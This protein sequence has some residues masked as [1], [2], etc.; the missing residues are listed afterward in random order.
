MPD[1][2]LVLAK[3]GNS[4]TRLRR[5]EWFARFTLVALV[6]LGVTF[7]M[8]LLSPPTKA[9]VLPGA[10]IGEAG[11]GYREYRVGK[12]QFP[13]WQRLVERHV[14]GLGQAGAAD[15]D[16]NLD[17]HG[18]AKRIWDALIGE[19]RDA[20]RER[21]IETANAFFNRFQH[22]A[23]RDVW[24]S[25]DHWASPLEFLARRRGDCEDFAAAKYFALRTAG[26]GAGELRVA[27]VLVGNRKEP[28]AHAILLVSAAGTVLA[29][30]NLSDQIRPFRA[31]HQYRL[32]YTLNEDDAWIHLRAPEPV[33][34]PRHD[35]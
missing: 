24:N 26:F 32:L 18:R 2:R 28:A 29:L 12:E 3:L 25:E 20:P 21:R 22:G 7:L 33:A 16:D 35:S 4:G 6:L 8:F 17:E 9:G 19:L 30:D 34:A 5:H 23:D 10:N 13:K 11:P 31:L 14:R 27:V 1:R 15:A